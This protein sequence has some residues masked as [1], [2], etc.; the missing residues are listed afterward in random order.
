MFKTVD[1]VLDY[2]ATFLKQKGY[3]YTGDN[4]NDMEFSRFYFKS[5]NNLLELTLSITKN[6]I[7]S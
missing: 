2:V 5:G 3:D 6:L 1:E 4:E 7:L